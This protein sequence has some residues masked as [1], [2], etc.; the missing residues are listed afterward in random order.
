MDANYLISALLLAQFAISAIITRSLLIS[1]TS[2]SSGSFSLLTPTLT[3]ATTNDS[4]NG[5][6]IKKGS[7]KISEWRCLNETC[8]SLSKFC[9]GTPDC[10]DSSD[11]PNQCNGKHSNIHSNKFRPHKKLRH[12]HFS[13]TTRT[14][15]YYTWGCL[16]F[17]IWRNRIEM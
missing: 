13:A 2:E 7:C 16:Q 8:I 9:D 17:V 11:E 15:L 14:Y 10:L 4:T 5:D 6:S 12:Q 1:A 3:Y